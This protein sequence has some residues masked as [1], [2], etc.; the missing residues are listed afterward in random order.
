MTSPAF[1]TFRL[2]AMLGMSCVVTR[3]RLHE[4]RIR[5]ILATEIA[6]KLRV[7]LDCSNPQRGI[8]VTRGIPTTKVNAPYR[9]CTILQPPEFYN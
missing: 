3:P 5:G 9:Y 2:V 7:F 8:L 4:A 6:L 1:E